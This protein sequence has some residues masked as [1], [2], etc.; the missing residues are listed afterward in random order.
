MH[1]LVEYLSSAAASGWV[2]L[3]SNCH[4]EWVEGVVAVALLYALLLPDRG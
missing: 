4:G 3:L 1:P 2:H